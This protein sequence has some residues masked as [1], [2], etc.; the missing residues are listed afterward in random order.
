MALHLIVGDRDFTHLAEGLNFST[1][2]PGGCETLGFSL[3]SIANMPL[4][5][6]TVVLFSGLTCVFRGRV[7][8]PGQDYKGRRVSGSITAIGDGAALKDTPYSMVYVDRDLN[9][10]GPMSRARRQAFGGTAS[11]VGN[12]PTVEP[13]PTAGSPRVKT[14]MTGPWGAPIYS[15]AL[16]DAGQGNLIGSVYYAWYLGGTVSATDGNWYATVGTLSN[17]TWTAYEATPDL[18]VGATSGSGTIVAGAGRRFSALQHHY[19]VAAGANGT[20]YPITWDLVVYGDHGLTKRGTAPEGF[21]TGD[22]VRHALSRATGIRVGNIQLNTAYIVPHS[23][24]YTPAY[25]EQVVDDMALLEGYHWGVWPVPEGDASQLDF[26]PPPPEPTCVV[27]RYECD[28]VQMSQRLSELHDSITVMYQTVGGATEQVTVTRPN[29][30]L[31]SSIS[32]RAV[33]SSGTD[34]AASAT[35]FGAMLLALEEQQS[36]AAGSITVHGSVMDSRGQRIGVDCLRAGVDRIKITDLPNSG[37]MGGI[38]TRAFDTFHIRRTEVTYDQ[39]GVPTARLELDAG[40]N[41]IEVLQARLALDAQAS[42]GG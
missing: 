17:D 15:E 4:P 8:E 36:R 22:I 10:W 13:D 7:E 24:Y 32:R 20:E 25:P 26:Q 2:D 34:T 33:V 3:P 23:V 37:P 41:L 19:M 14:G 5:G 9:R 18:V 31:P 6:D 1:A 16:Y 35:T 28:P 11:I 30:R 38:D 39:E 40:A 21:Y 12:D 29:P 27:S 42:I